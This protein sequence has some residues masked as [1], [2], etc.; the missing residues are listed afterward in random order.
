MP[1]RVP[2]VSTLIEVIAR[3][4]RENARLRYFSGNR[5]GLNFSSSPKSSVWKRE[6]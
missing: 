6:L 1:Y 5:F 3:L 2:D 4:E